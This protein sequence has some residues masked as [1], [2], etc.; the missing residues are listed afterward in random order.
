MYGNVD[1]INDASST[2]CE[3]IWVIPS[4]NDNYVRAE[5]DFRHASSII[6]VVL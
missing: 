5:M 2:F 6:L 1:M 3:R 4:R